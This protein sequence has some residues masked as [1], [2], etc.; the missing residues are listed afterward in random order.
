[1]GRASAQR[2]ADLWWQN[3]F[4]VLLTRWL[5][6]PDES[7]NKTVLAA[8]VYAYPLGKALA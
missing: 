4:G 3:L 2:V 5:V 6:Q 7:L 1:M 8:A